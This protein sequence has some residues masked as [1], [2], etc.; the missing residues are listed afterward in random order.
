MSAANS[1]FAVYTGV[2]LTLFS[3]AIGHEFSILHNKIDYLTQET[4]KLKISCNHNL[5]NKDKP[6]DELFNKFKI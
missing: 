1:F 3:Y 4:N 6:N 5:L 2:F